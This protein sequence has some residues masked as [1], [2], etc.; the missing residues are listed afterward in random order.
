MVQVQ[1]DATGTGHPSLSGEKSF[2]DPDWVK[3]RTV[4]LAAFLDNDVLSLKDVLGVRDLCNAVMAQGV[5]SHPLW[6]QNKNVGAV[7]LDDPVAS[8]AYKTEMSSRVARKLALLPYLDYDHATDEDNLSVL[9][10]SMVQAGFRPLATVDQIF[11]ESQ[12]PHPIMQQAD[13]PPPKKERPRRVPGVVLH[14]LPVGWLR[15]APYAKQLA[16]LASSKVE[17]V[18]LSFKS[19]SEAEQRRLLDEIGVSVPVSGP[20]LLWSPPPPTWE[21]CQLT[22]E[23]KWL[24]GWRPCC[25]SCRHLWLQCQQR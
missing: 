22:L 23:L 8:A 12:A 10:L 9:M 18:A 7:D 21:D 4:A 3:E 19:L 2:E 20:P 25:L 13:V 11:F 15:V 6:I 24:K 16:D 17:G 1:D 14:P 5:A